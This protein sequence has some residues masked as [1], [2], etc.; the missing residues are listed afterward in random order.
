M[1][2]IE[3]LIIISFY[4]VIKNW[5][6]IIVAVGAVA[7]VVAIDFMIYCKTGKCIKK[8]LENI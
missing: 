8:Y 5:L 1:E 2:F 3:L 7:G 6:L 4:F